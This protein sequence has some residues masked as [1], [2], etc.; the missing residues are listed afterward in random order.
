MGGAPEL[1]ELGRLPMPYGGNDTTVH[2]I[3]NEV[4]AET[5]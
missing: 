1:Y 5:L 3:K 2:L 4:T